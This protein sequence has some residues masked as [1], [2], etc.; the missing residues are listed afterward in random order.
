M[1]S[2]YLVSV[3]LRRG[4]RAAPSPPLYPLVPILGEVIMLVRTMAASIATVIPATLEEPEPE[5]SM[6][7][8]DRRLL[9]DFPAS[10]L[11]VIDTELHEL[12]YELEVT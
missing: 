1:I 11:D 5:P 2:V 10:N 12:L 6:V 7:V 9:I 3:R 4:G 8:R